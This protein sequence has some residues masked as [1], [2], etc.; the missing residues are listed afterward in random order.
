RLTRYRVLAGHTQREEPAQWGAE[1]VPSIAA[2]ITSAGR[3]ELTRALAQAGW[4][5]CYYC[6]TD[7]LMCHPIAERNLRSQQMCDETEPGK[8]RTV[9]VS[10]GALIHGWKSYVAGSKSACSGIPKG[11][12]DRQ[13]QTVYAW[14]TSWVASAL[15][16]R[17]RPTAKRTLVRI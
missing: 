17:Q 11:T 8:L 1:S 5:D 15:R 10:D 6:D 16:S 2:W 9:E 13:G 7:S 4:K 12:A 14:F 3:W